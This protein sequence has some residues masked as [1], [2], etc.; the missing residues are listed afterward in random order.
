VACG[1]VVGW[2]LWMLT[3]AIAAAFLVG[4]GVAS[5]LVVLAI[6]GTRQNQTFQADAV[7]EA[8]ARARRQQVLDAMSATRHPPGHE[9]GA[10]DGP[11][12]DTADRAAE[13]EDGRR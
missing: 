2:L 5:I 4:A 11:G 9:A 8:D 7:K 3:A 12:A 13:P 6:A 10:A 1:A